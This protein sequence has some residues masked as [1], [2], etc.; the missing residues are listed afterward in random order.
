MVRPNQKQW[1]DFVKKY[2]KFDGESNVTAD[3]SALSKTQGVAYFEYLRVAWIATREH[4]TEDEFC[5]IN[6]NVPKKFFEKN[7]RDSEITKSMEIIT[8]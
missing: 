8:L 2:M 7:V 1:N 6:G 5:R 4:F 3:F